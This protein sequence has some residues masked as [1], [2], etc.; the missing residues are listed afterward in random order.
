MKGREFIPRRGKRKVWVRKRNKPESGDVERGRVKDPVPNGEPEICVVSLHGSSALSDQELPVADTVDISVGCGEDVGAEDGRGFSDGAV[1]LLKKV[2]YSLA[3]KDEVRLCGRRFAVDMAGNVTYSLLGRPVVTF[4]IETKFWFRCFVGGYSS[5]RW[6]TLMRGKT[7]VV[8]HSTIFPTIRNFLWADG[9]R[10]GTWRF[11]C[12]YFVP[13]S[14]RV[15]SNREGFCWVDS[16][17]KHGVEWFDIPLNPLLPKGFVEKI[18]GPLR[19]VWR[20]RSLH[21]ATRGSFVKGMDW[22]MVGSDVN[23]DRLLSEYIDPEI[24]VEDDLFSQ[25]LTSAMKKCTFK[26]NSNLMLTLDKVLATAV[27]NKFDVGRSDRVVISQSLTEEQRTCFEGMVRS[28]KF[29]YRS[30]VPGPHPILNA[31]RNFI[32]E[33]LHRTFRDVRVSDIGGNLGF[34]SRGGYTNVHVCNPIIDRRDGLRALRSVCGVLR[35]SRVEGNRGNANVCS[36]LTTFGKRIC[37]EKVPDCVVPAA[38]VLMVDVYDVPLPCLINAM[39]KK[40]AMAAYVAFMFA[41]E[42]IDRDGVVAYPECQLMMERRG[43]AISYFVGD[44][45]ENYC[46]SFSSVEGYLMSGSIM[47][48]SGIV[49]AVSVENQWGPY[50]CFSVCITRGDTGISTAERQLQTWGRGKSEVCVRTRVDGVKTETTVHFDR[51]FTS[52]MILY[53]SNTCPSEEDRTLE[54][55]ISA[56]RSHKTTMVAGSKII[57]RKVEISNDIVV[58]V[59][60]AFLA[61]SV[62]RRRGCRELYRNRGVVTVFLNNLFDITQSVFSRVKMIILNCRLGRRLGFSGIFENRGRFI[63]D[64][65][66]Y[67]RFSIAMCGEGTFF[68][69]KELQNLLDMVNDL[70]LRFTIE[71]REI[72]SGEKKDVEVKEEEKPGLFGGA[73]GAWYDFLLP[74]R[75]KNMFG[76]DARVFLWRYLRK[77][78]RFKRGLTESPCGRILSWIWDKILLV[79]RKCLGFFFDG[80]LQES[81]DEGCAVGSYDN[82]ENPFKEKMIAVLEKL[83]G[84][85]RKVYKK[86]DAGPERLTMM[87]RFVNLRR[88]FFQGLIDRGF[89]SSSKYCKNE[90]RWKECGLKILTKVREMDKRYVCTR[91]ACVVGVVGVSTIAYIHR[92]KLLKVSKEVSSWAWNGCVS[93]IWNRAL[94]R[95]LARTSLDLTRRINWL[96]FA[97]TCTGGVSSLTMGALATS[98]ATW[99]VP[100]KYRVSFFGGSIAVDFLRRRKVSW[101]FVAGLPSVDDVMVREA[102]SGWFVVP[103]TSCGRVNLTIDPVQRNQ[104]E[105]LREIMEKYRKAISAPED[106]GISIKG[107]IPPIRLPEST[108]RRLGDFEASS[109]CGSS[110]NRVSDIEREDRNRKVDHDVGVVEKTDRDEN[111]GTNLVVERSEGDDKETVGESESSAE[112]DG[113]EGEDIVSELETMPVPESVQGSEIV[114]EVSTDKALVQVGKAVQPKGGSW[115]L[116]KTVE[117]IG[118]DVNLYRFDF[119]FSCPIPEGGDQVGRRKVFSFSRNNLTYQYGEIEHQALAWPKWLEEIVCFLGVGKYFDHCL[120]Q[121]YEAGAKIG[122][123]SDNEK[124]YPIDNAILTINVKGVAAFSVQSNGEERSFALGDGD[125]FFMPP[126]FQRT[127]R[128]AVKAVTN[129]V[130]LT[131]RST[132]DNSECYRCF[133]PKNLPHRIDSYRVPEVG[134][135]KH[136]LRPNTKMVK[137]KLFKIQNPLEKVAELLD[138]NFITRRDWVERLIGR[139]TLPRDAIKGNEMSA[140]AEVVLYELREFHSSLN[141]LKTLAGGSWVVDANGVKVWVNGSCKDLQSHIIDRDAPRFL[142]SLRDDSDKLFVINLRTKEIVCAED[143][144]RFSVDDEFAYLTGDRPNFPYMRLKRFFRVLRECD[145]THLDRCEKVFINAVPGGGKTFELV[146]TV[147]AA[148]TGSVVA[149]CNRGSAEDISR[150]LVDR[151][152]P[153]GQIPVSTVDSLLINFCEGKHLKPRIFCIDECF[154]IH[155]GYLQI[156]VGMVQ[157]DELRLYGDRR[158]IP[159]L[160]RNAGMICI[161]S[162]VAGIGGGYEE[163]LISYRCPRDICWWMSTCKMTYGNLYEGK[164]VCGDVKKPTKSVKSFPFGVFDA[165]VLK[166][167]DVAM[168]FTQGEKADLKKEISKLGL[169]KSCGQVMTVH[170]AQGKTFGKVALVRTKMVDDEIFKSE[171]HR[172]VA[173]TRHTE[174]L[175]FFAPTKKIDFGI[176]GDVQAIEKLEVEIAKEFC[177][178]QCS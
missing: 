20:G 127:H 10:G 92:K 100:E 156:I 34:V 61:E 89:I 45:G 101:Q 99:V 114:E 68:P 91:G 71:S 177:V 53:L 108:G 134:R 26:E 169:D 2:F 66:D 80:D 13:S 93:V 95:D 111:Q 103:P 39:E 5:P 37:R 175:S 160:N 174:S 133:D 109:S 18:C 8:K 47:S 130:S 161:A 11:N 83:L 30:S 105:I 56:L 158:Q 48:A 121:V 162:D 17:L 79:F 46:H 65:D 125:F 44:A 69:Y 157:P 106:E 15:V 22:V 28:K 143:M 154:M 86:R 19:Y 173:L 145:L 138:C 128:H 32:N 152:V 67:K 57:H 12:L 63:R 132:S 9:R 43:N 117:C 85:V 119:P 81:G 110:R 171:P 38:V 176:G 87:A 50:I 49:Y 54:Y 60:G 159:F 126:G 21:V 137:S 97:W 102:C 140:V 40:G 77:F 104:E 131:L 116:A 74:T 42:L 115:A 14:R 72:E 75:K 70:A 76:D 142:K 78:G 170:E 24:L 55:A 58:E 16:F 178:E 150:A 33:H 149:T 6:V 112:C 3:K 31:L 163:R 153:K 82:Q 167:S 124:C 96:Q 129:R 41:P 29:D 168:V 1:D 136:S 88:K 51:D 120:L 36:L 84:A 27:K 165:S 52:R 94:W 122:F 62:R 59:A 135:E 144:G 139:A 90:N 35:Q 141:K 148:G 172:L 166:G 113:N 164:V 151:K 64:C 25:T 155:R 23:Y 98:C 73:R 123:H 146:N 4:P 7:C 147:I 107:E 118:V